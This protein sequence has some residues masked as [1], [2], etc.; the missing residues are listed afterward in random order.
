[1]PAP[2]QRPWRHCSY[3]GGSVSVDLCIGISSRWL[4]SPSQQWRL[5]LVHYSTNNL[6]AIAAKARVMHD[7]SALDTPDA[8]LQR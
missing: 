2:W 8:G 1:M 6:R 3:A 5:G 4:A 7:T